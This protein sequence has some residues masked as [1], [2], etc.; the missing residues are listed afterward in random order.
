MRRAARSAAS[1]RPWPSPRTTR[2]TRTSPVAL[3]S[4]SSVTVPSMR[5]LRASSVYSGVGLKTISTGRSIGAGAAGSEDR[6]GALALRSNPA[7]LTSS[8]PFAAPRAVGTMAPNPPVVTAAVG[9]LVVE[10]AAFPNPPVATAA[11]DWLVRELLARSNT[12]I[13]GDG[14]GAL[15]SDGRWRTGTAV[16]SVAAAGATGLTAI[17]AAVVGF[18][19]SAS[20]RSRTGRGS[21]GRGGTRGASTGIA[22]TGAGSTDGQLNTAIDR[23][24][25]VELFSEARVGTTAIRTT[26]N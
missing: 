1:S 16:G 3:N 18:G 23:G 17:G 19:T 13:S 21:S 9:W 24:R 15:V 8:A 7:V 26:A 10:V 2:S 22:R 5:A 25:G 4:R 11:A 6:T 14:S 20:A 12:P